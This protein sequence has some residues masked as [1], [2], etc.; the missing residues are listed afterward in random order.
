MQNVI[1]K[2][3]IKKTY[4]YLVKTIKLFFLNLIYIRVIKFI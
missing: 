3:I 1:K 2:A 4:I